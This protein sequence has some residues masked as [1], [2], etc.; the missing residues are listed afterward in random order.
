MIFD[1]QVQAPAPGP[2]FVTVMPWF[3]FRRQ[4][5]AYPANPIPLRTTGPGG[6]AVQWIIGLSEFAIPS[7]STDQITLIQ[8]SRNMQ[9]FSFA[10]HVRMNSAHVRSVMA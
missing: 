10:G 4:S 8:T 1:G 7:V 2:N 5:G 3:C 9:I 6:E